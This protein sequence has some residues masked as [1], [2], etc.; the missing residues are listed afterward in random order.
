LSILIFTDWFEPAY[1][2]G[3]PV[4]SIMNMV[5]LLKDEHEIYVFT[6]DRDLEDEKPF[7][8]VTIDQWVL[9]D[10]FKVFYYSPGMMTF[11]FVR[12]LIQELTPSWIYL[13]SMFSNMIIPMLVAYHSKKIIIAPRGMLKPSALSH[14]Y[15]RK[16]FYCFLL[17][18]M[19]IDRHIRFH[20]LDLKEESEIRKVFPNAGEI[21][22]A[23]NIPSVMIERTSILEKIPGKLIILFSAR[24]HPIKN[25]YFLLD[26]MKDIKEDIEFKIA[27]IREDEVYYRKCLLLS[28]ELPSNI[29]VTWIFDLSSDGILQLLQNVHLFILPT[30]GESFGHSIFEALSVGCPVLISN[31]T[32]WK[33]LLHRKAGIDLPLQKD[34]FVKAIGFF[35]DM[36]EDDWKKFSEGARQF[37]VEFMSLSD[38]SSH[39]KKLFSRNEG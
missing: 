31:Q 29:S 2:A 28:Q 19:G 15:L 7:E 39:Y 36:A 18:L 24:L 34:L 8:T 12:N 1:K 11:S 9:R 20:A 5:R 21:V 38:T 23:P 6:A 16:Y 35:T 37:A 14:K 26:L 22:I 27:I 17:R 10:G 13:N 4:K 25:L 3:G 32:P 30:E 33:Q